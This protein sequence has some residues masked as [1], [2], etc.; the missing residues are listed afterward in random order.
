MNELNG[1]LLAME[2]VNHYTNHVCT[3]VFDTKEMLYVLEL[4]IDS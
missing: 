2:Q 3:F 1:Y 4:G